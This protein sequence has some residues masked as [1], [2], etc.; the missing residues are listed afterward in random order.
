MSQKLCLFFARKAS[1]NDKFKAWFSEPKRRNRD[2]PKFFIQNTRTSALK[3]SPL[4]YL[5]ELLNNES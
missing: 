3:K 1:K 2:T 4:I 5:A